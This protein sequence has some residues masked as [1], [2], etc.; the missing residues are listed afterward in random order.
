MNWKITHHL[1]SSNGHSE[2]DVPWYIYTLPSFVYYKSWAVVSDQF[3]QWRRRKFKVTRQQ[4]DE[5][6]I[7][8][9][10]VYIYF[11][12]RRYDPLK[13][14]NWISSMTWRA[15]L[16]DIVE[17]HTSSST[18]VALEWRIPNCCTFFKM[19]WRCSDA[20]PKKLERL[21]LAQHVLQWPFFKAKSPPPLCLPRTFFASRWPLFK[22]LVH[23][24]LFCK[25]AV[26]V[27]FSFLLSNCKPKKGSSDAQKK[28]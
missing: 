27:P 19:Q 2:R 4:A 1:I 23:F 11:H 15:M 20:I 7:R 10:H 18:R 21:F 14:H 8:P 25:W 24:H 28:Y 22:R 16:R 3:R 17:V 13:T 12:D 26:F 6:P 9:K 5:A